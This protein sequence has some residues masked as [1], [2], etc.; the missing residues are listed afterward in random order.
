MEHLESSFANP[1]SSHSE[2]RR[3]RKTIDE[4]SDSILQIC[5][6]Q[7]T[8]TRPD[9]LIFTSGGTESNNLALFGLLGPITKSTRLIVSSIEHPSVSEAAQRIR[10]L[11]AKVD[12]VEVN[13]QGILSVGHLQ[14]L[15]KNPAN[16]VSVMSVNNETGVVQP[17][18][19]IAEVCV[20]HEV[21]L[22]TDAVQAIGKS[23]FDFS[24]LSLS[25]ATLTPHKFH[26]PRGI[27]GLI[28]KSGLEIQPCFFGGFQQLGTRP[29]TEDT[30]LVAGFA[31]ALR[32]AR[33][34]L[35]ERATRISGL[36]DLFEQA[37]LGE[38][39]D[40]IQVLGGNAL[41]APHVSN[42]SFVGL[43]RQAVVIA[44]DLAGVC[45]STGSACASGSS[46]LSP[47][48]LAMALGEAVVRG[49][50]RFSFSSLNE[51]TEVRL[52]VQKVVQVVQKLA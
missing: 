47:A 14:E 35:A 24:A 22:H 23:A 43:D 30:A 26:G 27:G 28:L 39:G 52:A 48:I 4:C 44:L 31:A 3:A 13:Q 6:A 37:L 12:L 17:L 9:R 10:Q 51:E 25:A 32:L 2:G 19:Q 36:R 21:P 8:G 15:L 46:E 11:G 33:D 1:A 29:G 16:L 40:Q 50:V 45:C 34:E 20:E 49:A 7:T 38:L 18:E 5:G 42:I 41:R